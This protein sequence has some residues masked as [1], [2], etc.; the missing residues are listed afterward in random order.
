MDAAVREWIREAAAGSN[1]LVQYDKHQVPQ[2]TFERL[3]RRIL[4][5]QP[6]LDALFAEDA[7]RR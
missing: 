6:V 3:S 2:N 7:V 4:F 5:S 1:K